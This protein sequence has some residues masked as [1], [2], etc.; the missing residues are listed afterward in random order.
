MLLEELKLNFELLTE[1]TTDLSMQFDGVD[2]DCRKKKTSTYYLAKLAHSCWSLNKLLPKS[3]DDFFDFPSIAAICRN[4]IELTNLCWY[5][6]IDDT[7]LLESEFRFLLYDF[8]DSTALNSIF[9]NLGFDM[10]DNDKLHEEK[11]DYKKLIIEHPRYQKLTAEEKKQVKKG[12]KS[13]LQNQF[14]IVESR[15]INSNEFHGIYKLLSTHTHSTATSI[16]FLTHSRLHSTDMN[17]AFLGLTIDYTSSFI[18][19][20][21]KS[22]GEIWHIEFAKSDSKEFIDHF[23]EQLYTDI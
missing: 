3:D 23:V 8:H 7:D 18:A 10:D 6:C 15:R 21:V 1:I 12:R 14:Q 17:I 4:I 20:M 11:L 16:N 2:T 22:I 9:E 13:T 5:Y 19:D